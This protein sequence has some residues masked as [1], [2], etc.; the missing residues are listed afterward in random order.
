MEGWRRV[1]IF[2][3]E[4]GGGRKGGH[5]RDRWRAP[6][7]AKANSPLPW[8]KVS[9]H[10]NS[11]NSQLLHIFLYCCFGSPFICL[12]CYYGLLV[13]GKLNVERR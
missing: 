11:F 9:C 10:E 13:L 4:G 2:G 7:D 12:S 1:W 5:H 6:M 3:F 8:L